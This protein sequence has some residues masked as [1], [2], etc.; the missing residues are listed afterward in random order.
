MKSVRVLA[1]ASALLLLTAA[2][3]A[4]QSKPAPAAPAA[5]PEAPKKF[6]PPVRGEA[7]LGYTVPAT[8]RTG[9]EIV[10]TIKVKNMSTTNSIVGLKV[11]EFWYD[12]GGQPVTGDE[13]RLKKPLL[14]GEMVDIVLHTPTNPKMDRNQ[15]KFSHANG[16]VKT[17][18]MDAK[19]ELIAAKPALAAKAPAAKPA[20]KAPAKKKK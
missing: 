5:A 14:P 12:K 2:A 19:G 10:T 7:V 8:K 13:Q 1:C 20:A 6:L 15:Y 11:E 9:N 17:E 16:T 18:K 4:G 3:Y